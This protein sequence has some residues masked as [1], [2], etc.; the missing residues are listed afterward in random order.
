M[1]GVRLLFTPNFLFEISPTYFLYPIFFFNLNP[2]SLFIDHQRK[3]CSQNQK[4]WSSFPDPPDFV[5]TPKSTSALHFRHQI[6]GQ[7]PPF[8]SSLLLHCC[9]LHQPT[10]LIPGIPKSS[11]HSNFGHSHPLLHSNFGRSQRSFDWKS[12]ILEII[13]FFLWFMI[14][15]LLIAYKVMRS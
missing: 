4:S 13:F 3:F 15:R 6:R 7:P 2:Q 8:L 12:L 14:E 11:A 1:F 5:A 9:R 10:L